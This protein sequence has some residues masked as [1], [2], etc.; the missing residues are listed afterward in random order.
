M[1]N[2]I[3]ASMMAAMTPGALR[4]LFTGGAPSV[5]SKPEIPSDRAP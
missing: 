3:V 4:E 2:R 5:P 1:G